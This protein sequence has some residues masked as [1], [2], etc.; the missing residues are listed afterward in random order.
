MSKEPERFDTKL[1]HGAPQIPGDA[2]KALCDPIHMSS[3]FTFDSIADAQ[4][5]MAFESD[6]YVYTRGNNPTLRLFEKRMA[7]LEGG[8]DG[9]AFASGMAAISSTILSF[10]QPGEVL[11][12]HRTLYGSSHTLLSQLLPKY[13]ISCIIADFTDL[14]ALK[15]VVKTHSPTVLYCESPANPDLA[16]ID[17][18]ALSSLA[19][20]AGAALV[21]DNTFATPYLQQPLS[22]GA[23][24]VVHSATKYICGHGDA[25]G[26]VA[27]TRDPQRAL[28]IK[29]EYM[30]ELGGVLSPFNAFLFLRGLKTLAVRMER[31]C[32]NAMRVARFL[33]GH[34][35]VTEVYYP[36]LESG[37]FHELATR[38]MRDYGA[39]ISFEV[40]GGLQA[41]TR[42]I[43]AC[44]LARIAVSL[45]DCETLIQLPAA[46][47]HAG[48]DRDHL[49][50]H[51]LTESM[52]RIS[53]GIEDP[54]D[55]IE[56]LKQALEAI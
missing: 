3:T 35:K 50:E 27:I 26:G 22:L 47:T 40:A 24:A 36:G 37:R 8:A 53:V 43:D 28:S 34:S 10:C 21:V 20:A 38:Q 31:H 17:L 33:E 4:K 15:E 48:Y 25:V 46:M 9:V 23:D 2:S 52:L 7:L 56:D 30:C 11:F 16:I 49:A 41:A 32:R 54:E 42:C 1:I 45:G 14:Q 19:H 6:D 39:V 12:I 55:I 29:F 18:E 51:G 5:V 44:R 13:G